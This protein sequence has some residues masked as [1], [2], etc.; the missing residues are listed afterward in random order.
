MWPLF[1]F[2]QVGRRDKG[3]PDHFAHEKIADPFR[4]FT[5]RLVSLL[6][7]GVFFWGGEQGRHFMISA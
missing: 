7:I 6:R 2:F 5:V 1:L 4:I 3:R